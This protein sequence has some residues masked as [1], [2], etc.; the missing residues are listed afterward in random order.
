VGPLI[1]TSESSIGSNLRRVEAL[2]GMA[3]YDHLVSVRAA[4]SKAGETLKAAP[5]DV[6]A[7]VEQLLSRVTGLEKELDAIRKA[8]Q[9]SVAQELAAEAQR[10][11]ESALV[12]ADVGDMG[13]NE[14][15]QV[16]LSVRDRLAGS[17]I[18]I[19]GSS[20][21]GKGALIGLI[22]KDLVENGLSA[23]ELITP[24]ARILGGGGSRDPELAQAGGPR[25]D[26]LESA[27]NAARS[28]AEQALASL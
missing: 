7:R 21:G 25:G 18:V 11:G 23:A 12:V 20:A 9:G 6:P 19:V 22:S 24:A 10:I 14:L 17:G 26:Q 15:R 1:I 3:A 4:L 5:G 27:L 16:A 13:G 2:T 28:E 8:E